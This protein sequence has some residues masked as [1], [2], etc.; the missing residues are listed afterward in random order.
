MARSAC[1]RQNHDFVHQLS[2]PVRQSPRP[3]LSG[4][5]CSGDDC[6]ADGSPRLPDRIGYAH[7]ALRRVRIV[8]ARLTSCDPAA[9]RRSRA[10]A[11]WKDGESATGEGRAPTTVTL[12]L[13]LP[14]PPLTLTLTLTGAK[15]AHADKPS[16]HV[17]NA[18]LAEGIGGEVIEARASKARASDARA[19]RRAARRLDAPSGQL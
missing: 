5:P 9:E 13:T 16:E 4:D 17:A 6:T 11:G 12:T 19:S 10:G 7:L 15:G 14:S 2:T 18:H 3:S 8:D 1:A